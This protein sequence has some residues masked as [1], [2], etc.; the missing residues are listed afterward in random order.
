V[1]DF[2]GDGR[3][4][5]TAFAS[6]NLVG[7]FKPVDSAGNVGFGELAPTPSATRSAH[8]ATFAELA[9]DDGESQ[10]TDP[11]Q[12]QII[13]VLI[14]LLASRSDASPPA[15]QETSRVTDGLSNT[16]LLF[17]QLAAGAQDLN[18]LFI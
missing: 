9:D 8:D 3:A 10:W 12:Q 6:D 11:R 14:G 15:P 5:Q 1:G 2:I 13:A 7:P 18:D 16:L 4:D 17:E